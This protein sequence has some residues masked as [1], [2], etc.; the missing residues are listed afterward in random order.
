MP[1][2][3]HPPVAR[4]TSPQPAL[5]LDRD[6]VVVKDCHYL[7]DPDL[8]E[9]MPG[10]AE[11]FDSARQA[12]FLVIGVS[13]QSGLGRGMITQD[14][15]EAVT[16]RMVAC[17]AQQ[18]VAFDD[19]LYCPHAPH[20]DCA[21]R[22]PRPGLLREA[23]LRWALQLDA[24]WVVGDKPSDVALGRDAG[25]GSILV[26][27]G[28]GAQSEAEVLTMRTASPWAIRAWSRLVAAV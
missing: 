10:V 3:N 4:N 19:F 25:L 22:K 26:R 23:E 11:L 12:G 7:A 21:C 28:Y 1:A 17:L 13:N 15:F 27:T 24:S 18:G 5:F 14:Q 2:W 8:V 6:G 20:E 9:L 16:R